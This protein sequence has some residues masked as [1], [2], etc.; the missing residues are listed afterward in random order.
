MNI[1]DIDVGYIGHVTF[2]FRGSDGMTLLADPYFAD[3][4][5]WNG[6]RETRVH[7]PA[8]EPGQIKRCDCIFISHIHG[9]H[10]D[11]HAVAAIAAATNTKVLACAEV[12]ESLA[13]EGVAQ[14]Q[15]LLIG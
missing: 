12:L 10:C 7:P 11:V 9:D 8:L 2:L 3:G 15:L 5:W 4:S 6:R 1:G 14:R 13:N